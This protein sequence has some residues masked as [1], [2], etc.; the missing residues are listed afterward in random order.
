MSHAFA[1]FGL[2]SFTQYAIMLFV[3]TCHACKNE[4]VIGRNVGRKE[5]CPS[6][7]AD[8]HCC[9]NCSFFDPPASKQCREPLAELVKE[10]SKAN[11]CD[12]YV[13]ADSRPIGKTECAASD[14]ARKALDE[15]FKK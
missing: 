8:L 15:L 13:L 7:G 1:I 14:H 5:T 3:I 9:L 4:L 6:C 11:F 2:S 10:K 12:Y